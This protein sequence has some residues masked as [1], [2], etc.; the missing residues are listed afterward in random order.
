MFKCLTMK[1]NSLRRYIVFPIYDI[2]VSSNIFIVG[3]VPHQ[4]KLWLLQIIIW[5]IIPAVSSTANRSNN[6][7]SMIVLIQYIPRVFLIV[8][9]NSKI[10]KASG[11]VTRTAWA[12][13]AYNL[14]LYTLASHVRTYVIPIISHLH[15]RSLPSQQRNA[16]FDGKNFI[17]PGPI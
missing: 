3:S 1:H 17:G 12:G 16:C 15:A 4:K 9:S 5:F 13:A 14:L 6:T 2:A 11:V 7:L 10:V 8:S